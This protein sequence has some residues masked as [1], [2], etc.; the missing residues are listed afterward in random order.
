MKKIFLLSFYFTPCTLTPSQ[1]IT[2]WAKN[3]HKI[4]LYPIVITRDWPEKIG[5]HSDTKIQ[6]GSKIRHEKHENFEVYYLPFKPGILD[7]SYLRWGEN[8]LRPLFLLTKLLD[9]I[10]SG[11]TLKFSSFSN[12][13]PLLKEIQAKHK[14]DQL[15][16]SGEPFYLF[17]IGYLASKKLGLSWIADYRDDW[18]T[19]ELQVR[20]S[21]GALRKFL[22]NTESKYEKKWVGTASHIISVSE[23]YTKRIASF[24]KKPGITIQNG[25]EE[26]L[27]EMPDVEKYPDFTIAYSGVLYPSQDISILL[28][29]LQKAKAAQNPFNLIFLG[30]GFDIKEKRRIESII[31]DDLK[32]FVKI[33][34]RYPR[35]EAIQIL[36]KCHAVVSIAY[37]N[38]KGIPSSKLYEYLALRVPILLCPSDGD[39]MEE[40]VLETGT[41]FVCNDS[42]TLLKHIDSIR[43]QVA[44]GVLPQNSRFHREKIIK[45]SRL[46]QL[47]NIKP[48]L[49]E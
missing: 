7:K 24:V 28:D 30:T 48:I 27:L 19:N 23:P 11:F 5:S 36:K 47:Q 26:T 29:A 15:I 10:I 32:D 38:M 18:S 25:F 34:D 35:N 33:T 6:F 12:F 21:G 13:Y 9:V 1:R 37:G 39:V 20:K 42:E 3:F 31:G 2:Y 40:I 44:A 17:K 16:I 22:L 41:G 43:K 14:L 45:Y 46:S 4:G 8:S 49:N